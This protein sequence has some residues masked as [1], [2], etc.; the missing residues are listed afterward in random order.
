MVH[1]SSGKKP[2][3]Q[4]EATNKTIFDVLSKSIPVWMTLILMLNSSLGVGFLE[5][6]IMKQNMSG[7]LTSLAQT[8]NNPDQLIQIL[9]QEVLPQ[10]GYTL[11]V[12]WNDI[13]KQLLDSGVIDKQK[14]EQN[15]AQEPKGLAIMKYMDNSSR[16]HMTINTDNAHFMVN[17]LWAL[18][19]VNKS[20]IL[21]DGTIKTYGKGDVMQFASTGGWNLGSKATSDLY[22]STPIIQLT[23]AQEALVEKIA[24]NIFRPCCS[25]PTLFP[26]CN[27]GMAAL[28]YIELAVQ[29]GLSE[30]RI[31]SDVLHLNEEW[32]PQQYVTLAAYFQQQKIDWKTIDP[33]LILS[34]KYSSGQAMQQ[35]QQA[36]QNVPGLNTQQGG[37]GS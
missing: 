17:T 1:T 11:G 34:E 24:A 2:T 21:D 14:Y 25:N 9:K 6:Y 32:F 31:Y 5:Y 7:A 13:G 20:K 18:G 37:C 27:H 33:K 35:I 3:K 36:T 10:Q 28:G 26:D 16:D 30:K 12:T 22:S 23:D 8:T 29:Q 19:L 15:F 4:L